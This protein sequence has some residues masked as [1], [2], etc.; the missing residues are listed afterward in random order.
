MTSNLV[1][2]TTNSVFSRSKRYEKYGLQIEKEDNLYHVME[3]STE[4]GLLLQV[5]KSYKTLKGAQ[6]KVEKLI[7][8]I[9]NMATY[10][11]VINSEIDDEKKIEIKADSHQSAKVKATQ[12][13]ENNYP[14]TYALRRTNWAVLHGQGAPM[15]NRQMQGVDV[16][17]VF[18][19]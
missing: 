7:S 2:K 3:Y 6:K 1:F 17:L 14:N 18:V 13:V 5:H 4:T 16:W 10:R 9:E 8:E 15:W 11:I 12:Y 19:G